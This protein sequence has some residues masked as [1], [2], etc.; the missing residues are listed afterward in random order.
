MKILVTGS[1]G[2]VGRQVVNDLVESGDTVYSGFHNLQPENGISTQ[3]DLGSEDKIKQVFTNIVN[4]ALKFSMSKPVVDIF[5][6]NEQDYIQTDLTD[7]GIGIAEA[8]IP[9]LFHKFQQIDTG[10]KRKLG[11]SG[12]GLAICKGIIE[13]HG[14]EIGVMS[15]LG[16]GSTFSFTL[17]KR[18]PKNLRLNEDKKIQNEI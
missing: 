15:K 14:G 10:S 13:T 4:N 17:P 7:N 3:M 9:K 8:D 1:A 18:K 16:E 5:I 2:L 11:G 12:L 6:K